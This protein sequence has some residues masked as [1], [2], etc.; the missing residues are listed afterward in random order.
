MECAGDDYWL[1][2]KVALQI[3]FM[4]EHPEYG[5]CYGKAKCFLER[6][7]RFTRNG[8][9]F[10][11]TTINSLLESNRI[12]ALTICMRTALLNKYISE[13]DPLSRNWQ[14]ED[15][16][17]WL[18]FVCTNKIYFINKNLAV[19]RYQTESVSHSNDLVKLENFHFSVI[20][21]KSVFI[22]RYKI[23]YQINL[24]EVYLSLAYIAVLNGQ[25]SE[26]KKQLMKVQGN[27]FKISIKKIIANIYL[28]F[29]MYSFCLKIVGQL[30]N[31]Y[32][33]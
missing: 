3:S 25:Y 16:P 8:I 21:I 30:F 22:E 26:Y 23:I 27:N 33:I 24:D 31:L 1:P 10:N 4:E 20:N 11:T 12:P 28:I 2:G 13:I 29:K 5:M 19:Y 32:K 17:I 6:K 15:Y 18:W 9:G 7:K 14:L